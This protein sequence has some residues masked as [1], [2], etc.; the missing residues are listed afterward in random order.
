[1]SHDS[2]IMREKR[3]SAFSL[4]VSHVWWVRWSDCPRRGGGCISNVGTVRGLVTSCG[5]RGLLVE[6]GEYSLQSGAVYKVWGESAFV[7]AAAESETFTLCSAPCWSNAFCTCSYDPVLMDIFKV[8]FTINSLMYSQAIFIKNKTF[9]VKY[10][11]S[12]VELRQL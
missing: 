9:Q 11:Q 8:W 2:F 1:M 5:G 3:L 4:T 7:N 12:S 10:K 6:F